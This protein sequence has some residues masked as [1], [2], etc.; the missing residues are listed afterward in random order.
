MR[1]SRP[2]RSAKKKEPVKALSF[3]SPSLRER[4]SNPLF[5]GYEPSVETVSLSR[6]SDL[7]TLPKRAP[8]LRE[9]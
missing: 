6:C 1:S 4:E 5:L 8:Q 3:L 7:I 9:Q 2:A